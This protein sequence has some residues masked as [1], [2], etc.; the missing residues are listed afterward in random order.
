MINDEDTLLETIFNEMLNYKRLYKSSLKTIDLLNNE[1]ENYDKRLSERLDEL[2][3]SN[4]E[5]SFYKK[6]E[7]CSFYCN[8]SK[9]L[10]DEFCTFYDSDYFTC[11]NC[12][13]K[14]MIEDEVL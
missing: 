3:K 13:N 5:L 14:K 1:I 9:T 8:D 12:N 11:K 10:S 6:L 4:L 2:D 7:N